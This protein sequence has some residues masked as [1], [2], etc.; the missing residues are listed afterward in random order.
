MDFISFLINNI[1]IFQIEKREFLFIIRWRDEHFAELIRQFRLSIRISHERR[2]H[3]TCVNRTHLDIVPLG[4]IDWQTVAMSFRVRR[5]VANGRVSICKVAEFPK[6]ATTRP[7]KQG[8]NANP[9]LGIFSRA[10][11]R[12]SLRMR[13]YAAQNIWNVAE[14]DDKYSTTRWNEL[15]SYNALCLI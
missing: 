2:C 8:R 12:D 3:V 6:L 5:S 4:L 15:L 10:N 1:R 13:I 14:I 9:N 7:R 11:K